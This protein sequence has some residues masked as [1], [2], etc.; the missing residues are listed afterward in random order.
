MRL[1]SRSW[2]PAAWILWILAGCGNGS[3]L[4]AGDRTA[5]PRVYT[6]Q[7]EPCS[8]FNPF[9]NLYFGDLHG[10]TAL[11]HET[12]ILD[13]RSTTADAYRFAG[14]ESILL[15]PLGEDGQ[16]TRTARL[17][18][19]L[20]FAAVTDHG[21][22]YGEVEACVN[23]ASR[24]YESQACEIYRLQN[25]LSEFIIAF[26]TFTMNPERLSDICGPGGEYCLD[27][28]RTVWQ[29]VR[30]AAEEAYDR[31][32][33][34][35]FSSFL[36][37]E[38]TGLP[39]ATNIHRNV[40]FRN[41][42]VPELPVSYFEQPD[43]LELWSDLRRACNEGVEGCDVMAIPHNSNESNGNKFA[44]D[45]G[46][47]E[48]MEEQRRIASLRAE[49][50]PLVEIFQHKGDSECMNGLSGVRS[51][52]DDLCE[53][54]KLRMAPVEDCGEDTGFGGLVGAGCVSRLDYVRFAL[55][56]GLAEE[57][58]LGVNPYKLG[59]IGST[60][61]H[62][63]APG[64]VDEHNYPG[65]WGIKEDTP[66]ERL[67]LGGI[68]HQ[69][70][71]ANPGG[72][73]AVWARENSRD[74]IFEALRRRET[75]G[76]SGPRIR[77]RLFGGWDLPLELCHDPRSVETGYRQ[78]VPM[79]GDLPP[80]P[81]EGVV[82]RLFVYAEKDPGAAGR[83]GTPLER[84]QIIKGWL[85]RNGDSV[86]KA[87]QVFDVAG[88]RDSSAG[89]DPESCETWGTDFERLCT[90]WVDET[91]DPEQR[92][93]YYVR[94]LENP[95]C[96]WSTWDC[97]RLPPEERPEACRDPQ[98]KKIIQERA[99]TSPIWYRPHRIR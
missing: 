93:F 67:T 56:E 82:P 37:Y 96:R 51:G 69:G 35:T 41:T 92:A 83:V 26:P 78:G 98:M 21:E 85:E 2:L 89:V 44:V 24:V 11:S 79:G 63:A 76:T 53:F 6:E 55:L 81:G 57:E 72:L 75:Y 48:T 97:I 64:M 34:C 42:R 30:E 58:R 22:F 54:E 88:S 45:Y 38:Y 70:L 18:R 49:V 27:W 71:I 90:V 73:A 1:K 19:P 66:G 7:R 68:T 29:Q 12:W 87:V 14:G 59:F 25:F 52:Y 40:L 8:D 84:I 28:A 10:H 91:F 77:V 36:S 99:W 94:V 16:G 23:P 61:T 4:P 39:M 33:A 62:N 65:H 5:E 95:T 32:S 50:E 43:P 80:W 31:T 17:E 15:P 9:R 60:D 13:V 74:E 47:A 3:S 86:I 46:D 20:D